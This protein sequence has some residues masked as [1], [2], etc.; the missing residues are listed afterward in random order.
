[1]KVTFGIL[2]TVTLCWLLNVVPHETKRIC[3]CYDFDANNSGQV[4]STSDPP[5]Q[6]GAPPN[7]ESAPPKQEEVEES[8]LQPKTCPGEFTTL[9][10]NCYYFSSV[11]KTWYNAL[12]HCKSMNA[13]LAYPLNEA[14]N[15]ALK[16]QAL[17]LA[18]ADFWYLG[19][20]DLVEKNVWR[21]AHSNAQLQ[22]SDW[23]A[24]QP[25]Y[26]NNRENC[27]FMHKR[28]KFL[29]GD[30][31]CMTNLNYI[32]QTVNEPL[33]HHHQFNSTDTDCRKNYTIYIIN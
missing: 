16:A 20:Q 11:Q 29:W 15:E 32:C 19:G 2:L 33:V 1:M 26:A 22:F 8:S 30:T 31:S 5:K 3:K 23:Y 7:Q 9:E 27:I 6:E 17:N 24:G 18:T 25:D 10:G 28:H 12:A 14:Q 13:S 4:S 21:W